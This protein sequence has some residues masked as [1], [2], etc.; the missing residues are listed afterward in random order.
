MRIQN[1]IFVSDMGMYKACMRHF[2]QDYVNFTK[3]IKFIAVSYFSD[4]ISVFCL[5]G[6]SRWYLVDLYGAGN[7]V[8]EM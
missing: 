7:L 4:I 2:F 8:A 5:F 1:L 3:I 6:I